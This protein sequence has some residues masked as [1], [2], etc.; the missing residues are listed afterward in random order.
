M[1]P[2]KGLGEIDDEVQLNCSVYEIG[3]VTQRGV[4]VMHGNNYANSVC[5]Q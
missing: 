1:N 3:T 2:I 5:F 4:N